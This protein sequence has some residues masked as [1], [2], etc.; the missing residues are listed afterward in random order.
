MVEPE[1]VGD[2]RA[3]R[4]KKAA[5]SFALSSCTPLAWLPLLE[6]VLQLSSAVQLPGEAHEDSGHIV[7]IT[8]STDTYLS[9][10]VVIL[11]LVLFNSL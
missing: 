10:E 7:V 4:K 3:S 2:H 11:V 6:H 8:V 1:K 9:G 5:N